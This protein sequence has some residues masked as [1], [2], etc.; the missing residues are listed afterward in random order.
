MKEMPNDVA[1]TCGRGPLHLK[2]VK[3][4]MEVY[5]KC[6]EALEATHPSLHAQVLI[7]HRNKIEKESD[8]NKFDDL[9]AESYTFK[10][11][12]STMARRRNIILG[13]EPKDH[14]SCDFTTYP[15]IKDNV[16]G[17]FIE[18]IPIRMMIFG[19]LDLHSWR[20]FSRQQSLQEWIVLSK[21]LPRCGN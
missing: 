12:K 16:M 8:K 17:N 13:P 10:S 18:V 6:S 15:D 19:C 1:H 7:K 20:R 5:E 21:L 3:F 11:M 4:A 9:I 2:A 14:A